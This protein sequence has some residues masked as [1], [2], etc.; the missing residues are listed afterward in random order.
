MGD[1]EKIKREALA[2]REYGESLELGIEFTTTEEIEVPEKLIDQVIGQEHAVEVIKTAANQKRHVLLIG[3][4]GTG[5]S[6]LGQA[7]AEL[8]PTETLEDILVFPNPEDENMPKIKTVPACQGR[9]IVEKYREKAKSQESVKSYI[10]LFV[11]FTVMLALFIE[12]S[13]TTL[14]M[15]LFVVIL[16]IMALSNMRLKSTVLVPKLLVDNCGRTK[17]PFIDATGAHAGALLG[18][19]RHDPFQSGGL[20]TPAHERVEPGMIHRAH[21]GVLFIDEIATLSLKMQQS[22]LTAMQEKKFPITGQSEMSSGAM[23]RTEPVPCDFVLVAAGNLDTVDKM[24]PALRS[25]IRGYGYEVY[26]RTTMPDTI[27]NR[28]KLV[29]FVAQEVKRDGKIPHFTKEA[30]EEIVREAQKRAGRKGHL[31]LR[32]R[33]LGGIVRAAGDI[34]VKKGKK[35]VERED[36]IEAVKMAKPLEKQLADWYIER[37][38]EYQVIKTEGSEIGRV[39]GLAVIGEQSGI[40]LPIEAVVAP[41]ASKEEGKI[42]VTGKLGEIAKEAVQNVSAI[43]KRYKGEDISRYDIHVQFLQTYEGVEGDS[44]SISVA[45]AVISALEE[46]PIRQDVAMTG[47]LSVRGEVLPI[48]G[49][50]PKI[51]AAIEAGIKTVIIPKSNEKD[52]FLSKD[53]AE[54]IQI[55]PVETIDEVLEI[56]LEESEKKRE[57][58][59]R[60]RE[61]LPLSL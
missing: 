11:M 60:I 46:I 45:T 13:A 42:I 21:K 3:E 53:K 16:T 61:T 5:K 43:I 4:P 56:A 7:M 20:G 40:V 54:K 12:F 55:F 49:A 51:E 8:L 28:R 30:V 9:R 31:T 52:V 17:A 22:L 33:D 50:T 59:R 23:V 1:D 36:V 35:Y 38:K 48:G 41:A 32:L 25:R 19:V 44:A 18:D 6:M 27:E 29:Q 2:P 15:G 24:H 47:S 14:L 57:L 26:M 58:L 37:K 34:A 10:L 39:N